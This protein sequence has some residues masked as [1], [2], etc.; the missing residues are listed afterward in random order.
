MTPF[1][2]AFAALGPGLH[3]EISGSGPFRFKSIEYAAATK[4]ADA[5][6][7]LV[8]TVP[9]GEPCDADNITDG[10]KSGV[11][12]RSSIAD[13]EMK[14][15]IPIDYPSSLN[16]I[17]VRVADPQTH[18]ANQVTITGLPEHR[19]PMPSLN[20]VV[21]VGSFWMAGVAY[22]ELGSDLVATFKASRDFPTGD[23]WF[24]RAKAVAPS[25]ADSADARKPLL[26]PSDPWRG[27]TSYGA[28]LMYPYAKETDRLIVTGRL[29][30]CRKTDEDFYTPPLDFVPAPSKD[31]AWPGVQ[32]MAFRKGPVSFESD[33]GIPFTA[34]TVSSGGG[35]LSFIPRLWASIDVSTEPSKLYEGQ[36]PDRV[37]FLMETLD[38][39][40]SKAPFVSEWRKVG[41]WTP[42]LANAK[43]GFV[44]MDEATRPGVTV[45]LKVQRWY[46]DA[47][48]PFQMVLP[49]SHEVLNS[50]TVQYPTLTNGRP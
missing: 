26:F 3:G 38:E 20:Q 18:V 22:P 30:H 9:P 37:D 2:L 48:Y 47:D 44:L 13:G 27:P 31:Q 16:A 35:S 8:L 40:H 39:G 5:Y 28:F 49:L 45:H 17:V 29:V 34:T 33:S 10:D 4:D 11:S 43:F 15:N 6:L 50:Q 36:V 14:V 7:R 24:L 42:G 1:I 12:L 19:A 25:Q 21:P 41:E 23:G 32:F 46:K